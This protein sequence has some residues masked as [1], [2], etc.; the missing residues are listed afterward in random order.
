M[1][2]FSQTMS[3]PQMVDSLS[4]LFRS[5]FMVSPLT[6]RMSVSL[7]LPSGFVDVYVPALYLYHIRESSLSPYQYSTTSTGLLPPPPPN[8]LDL[9]C[10]PSV[11]GQKRQ[12]PA[13]TPRLGAI[14]VPN[15]SAFLP[16]SSRRP[17]EMALIRTWSSSSLISSLGSPV[18]TSSHTSKSSR[19]AMLFL[20]LSLS[21]N[22]GARMMRV[23][24]SVMAATLTFI[25]F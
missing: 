2:L 19:L 21:S 18:R 4:C 9:T 13:M 5:P 22:S 12:G 23:L 3:M 1:I 8:M 6:S 16:S 7:R 11:S 25:G 17:V 10:F 24:I 15:G 14:L 20:I